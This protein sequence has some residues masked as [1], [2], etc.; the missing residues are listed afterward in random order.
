MRFK[1]YYT[2][3][4]EVLG[5]STTLYSYSL[6]FH[7]RVSEMLCLSAFAT[8]PCIM[9]I[10]EEEL[11]H[12][13]L[14]AKENGKQEANLNA[15]YHCNL[16]ELSLLHPIWKDTE[17]NKVEEHASEHSE[18]HITFSEKVMSLVVDS[19]EGVEEDTDFL[20]RGERPLCKVVKIIETTVESSK[21]IIPILIG[22]KDK[23]IMEKMNETFG[24]II[25]TLESGETY[26]VS[27]S[28]SLRINPSITALNMISEA[29]TVFQY[30]AGFPPKKINFHIISN[31]EEVERNQSNVVPKLQRQAPRNVYC[32][33]KPA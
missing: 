11:D 22:I 15:G 12:S 25:S 26:R 17:W 23:N 10:S 31:A 13:L 27:D 14:V 2:N 7:K 33:Q 1:F 32:Y 20:E 18:K 16:E 3:Q 5:E 8:S 4:L 21:T 30:F 19:K 9:E 6:S 24:D 28:S 29:H